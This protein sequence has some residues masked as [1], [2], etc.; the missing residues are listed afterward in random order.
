MLQAVE[1]RSLPIISLERANTGTGVAIL[2]I[3]L[4]DIVSFLNL[5]KTMSPA[6]IK[7]TVDLLLTD[8]E[9]KN[10]KPEDYKVLFNNAKRGVYGKNYDR[11]DG[12]I[13]FEWVRAYTAERMALCEQINYADHTV[14]KKSDNLVHPE[15]IEM[16]KKI[17]DEVKKIEVEVKPEPRKEKPRPEKSDRDKLIQSLFMEFYKLWEKNPVSV[18]DRVEKKFIKVDGQIMDEVEYVEFKLKSYGTDE[19][20]KH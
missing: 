6:Q 2:T 16:Y 7:Q 20:I 9:A 14:K 5:G 11:L 10:L 3:F 15:V 18:S 4:S 17:V 12:Q 13:V 8:P 19:N 1:S